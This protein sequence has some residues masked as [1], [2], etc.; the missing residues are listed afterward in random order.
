LSVPFNSGISI[1]FQ[2]FDSCLD[3]QV[4]INLDLID[5]RL[6]IDLEDVSLIG[7][8]E[9][10]DNSLSFNFGFSIKVKVVE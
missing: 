5:F 4:D 6:S 2:L 9:L 10:D 3:V 1:V 8:P 7:D